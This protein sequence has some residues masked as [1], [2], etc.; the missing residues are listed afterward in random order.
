MGSRALPRGLARVVRITLAVGAG[1][2]TTALLGCGLERA[3]LSPP[4]WSDA[5]VIVDAMQDAPA[6]AGAPS[7][8]AKP[9]AA[10]ALTCNGRCATTCDTCDAGP[11]ACP[12]TGAC[13]TCDSCPGYGVACYTCSGG[14]AGPPS[15]AAVGASCGASATRCACAPGS[16][17]QCP[18]GNQ[19]C[20]PQGACVS[21]GE[22]GSDGIT[23]GNGLLCVVTDGGAS[24]SG[25]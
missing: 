3:G 11:S 24:C 22:D 17:T 1:A 25:S 4:G 23:C 5:A 2:A 6:D 12:A 14:E 15:C 8:A 19:I 9:D 16:P 21:C 18:G 7:D 13:G 20:S 10:C